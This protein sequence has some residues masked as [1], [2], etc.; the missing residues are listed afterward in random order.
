MAFMAI[1]LFLNIGPHLITYVLPPEVYAVKERSL[2]SGL[3]AS[4]GKVGAVLAVFFIPIILEHGGIT[5][6][7]T[8]SISVMIIGGLVTSF[9]GPSVFRNLT[10]EK[11]E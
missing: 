4:L 5:A 10:K 1:E 11:I 9:V 2:G 7:L 6:V 3:A 8:V